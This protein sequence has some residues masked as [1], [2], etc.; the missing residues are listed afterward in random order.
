MDIVGPHVIPRSRLLGM[1]RDDRD[2][3]V[4]WWL[5][6]RAVHPPC[7]T[8]PEEWDPELGGDEHAYV[9]EIRGCRG[10]E[11]LA[12]GQ[13]QIPRDQAEKGAHVVLVPNPQRASAQKED[14][15]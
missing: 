7:G 3:Q 2:A 4:A 14:H 10:C 15:R 1:D 12:S 6:Q 8:R 9:A 11:T 13:Q 5:R